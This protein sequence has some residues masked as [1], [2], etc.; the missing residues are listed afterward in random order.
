MRAVLVDTP[1]E[2]CATRD[3]AREGRTR[4]PLVGVYATRARFAPPTPAE[5]FDRADVVPGRDGTEA[6]EDRPPGV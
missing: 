3:D 6:A 2:V 5:G 1:P 4:V